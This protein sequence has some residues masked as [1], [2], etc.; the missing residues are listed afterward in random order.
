[1]P[2]SKPNLADA[3]R[4]DVDLHGGDPSLALLVAEMTDDAKEQSRK[5]VRACTDELRANV[6]KV[7]PDDRS[8]SV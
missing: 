4:K 7:A 6:V 3:I 5:N 8:S 1:M 2:D